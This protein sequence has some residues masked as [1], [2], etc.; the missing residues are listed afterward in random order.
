M[1][2]DDPGQAVRGE[3]EWCGTACIRVGGFPVSVN[4]RLRAGG[5]KGALNGA[6]QSTFGLVP[7]AGPEVC[8]WHPYHEMARIGAWSKTFCDW[9]SSPLL[10]PGGSLDG[11]E[12]PPGWHGQCSWGFLKSGTGPGDRGFD[13]VWRYPYFFADPGTTGFRTVVP[14]GKSNTTSGPGDG[15]FTS[16]AFS[17]CSPPEENVEVIALK[18]GV[19]L[20]NVESGRL[21]VP[22]GG[23]ANVEVGRLNVPPVGT[24]NVEV[25]RLKVPVGAGAAGGSG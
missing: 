17:N 16:E 10:P 14:G 25:G 9:S 22:P 3:R 1:E 23:S 11:S 2:W 20:E 12:A 5:G 24:A 7:E 4:E 6:V 18:A 21:N 19:E 15:A 8:K 13:N